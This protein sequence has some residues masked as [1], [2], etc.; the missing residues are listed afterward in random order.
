MLTKKKLCD[1]PL[2]NK[3]VFL[4]CDLNVPLNS[5]GSILSSGRII[6]SLPTIVYALERGAKLVLL[7]HL[8]RVKQ[9]SDKKR[10]SLRVVADDLR[11]KLKQIF[12]KDVPVH[13][14]PFT[15]G[16]KLKEAVESLQNSE[17]LVLENTRFEDLNNKA[18]SK[19]NSVLA[20]E[21]AGLADIFINDAFGT[22]HRAHAS[23]VGIAEFVNQSCLGLLVEHE[24][25][26]LSVLTN[27]PKKPFI[28]IMGG[29]KISDKLGVLERLLKLVDR[30]LVGG[31]I[32]YTF[33]KAIGQEIGKS[34]YDKNSL[35]S[36]AK[37]YSE[38]RDKIV[39]PVDFVCTS[40]ATSSIEVL[41][42]IPP[43]LDSLDIGPK[44]IALF[45]S[46]ILSAKTIFWNGPLGYYEKPEFAV[47][48][49]SVAK[50]LADHPSAYIVIGGGDSAAAVS[51]FADKISHISTGG[52]A[53]LEYLEGKL[54]PGLSTVSECF[55]EECSRDCLQEWYNLKKHILSK[56]V[57]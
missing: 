38:Y 55:G 17:V 9:E 25:Q 44:T 4:R 19:N 48:T 54:L 30:L 50:V 56:I 23:N 29:A 27:S 52:G 1:V 45:E 14:S 28:A 20:K 37:L 10:L 13:F 12:E 24:I 57:L 49:E 43:H 8:G 46:H 22:T 42:T 32:A 31:G 26:Q 2:S 6:S 34:L 3:K 51:K 33:L 7:S 53:S 47:A 18:E 40:S 11:V 35:E 41:D 21:W 39:L 36:A 16:P 5:D 15:S